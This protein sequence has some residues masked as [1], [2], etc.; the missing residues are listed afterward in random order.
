MNRSLELDEVAAHS[1]GSL[2]DGRFPLE[3]DGLVGGGAASDGRDLARRGHRPELHRNRS[4]L[5]RP[6]LIH[7]WL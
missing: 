2:V 6:T 5:S 3:L 7:S 1:E 4:G